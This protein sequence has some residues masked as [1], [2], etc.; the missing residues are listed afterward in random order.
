MAHSIKP[1]GEALHF[2]F[3]FFYF[4]HEY[5]GFIKNPAESHDWAG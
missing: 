2:Y 5:T 1:E 4:F 3:P